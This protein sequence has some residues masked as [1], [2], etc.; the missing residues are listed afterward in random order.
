MPTFARPIGWRVLLSFFL[1]SKMKGGATVGSLLNSGTRL[2]S[3][4]FG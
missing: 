2:R 3:L 1:R 4:D